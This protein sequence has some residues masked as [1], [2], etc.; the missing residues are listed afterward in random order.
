MWERRYG[1]VSPTRTA[2]GERL[3]SDADVARLRLLDAAVAAGRR[4]SRVAGLSTSELEAL[5]AE[6]RAAESSRGP[7]SLAASGAQPNAVVDAALDR[8]RALDARGL[9]ELL[10]RGAAV[11][12]APAF[13]EDSVAPLLRRI[14]DLWHAGK[15][16]IAAEH[17]ASAVIESFVADVTRSL[18]VSDA[19]PSVLVATPAGS[20][21]VMGASLVAAAA[22]AE[23][24]NVIFL[25]GDLP[26]DEIVRTAMDGDVRAVAVSVVY[27]ADAADMLAQLRLLREQL[28]PEVTLLA[29]GRAVMPHARAL[30]RNGVEIGE[31]LDALRQGLR[32][33]RRTE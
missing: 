25:G 33:L 26:V 16:S 30:S 13:L 9:D 6:D 3:Y 7:V 19:A 8:V 15:I 28:P 5:I 31:S 4:I 18:A 14:G 21:H 32:R 12:G 24:W 29:G 10:R 23:G 22:A 11:A 2:G 17:V 1:A 20:R 27:A